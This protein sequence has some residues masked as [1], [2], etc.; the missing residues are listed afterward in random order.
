M[1]K[2][3]GG[4]KKKREGKEVVENFESDNTIQLCA[5]LSINYSQKESDGDGRA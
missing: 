1:E 5:F 3:R 4:V 2:E